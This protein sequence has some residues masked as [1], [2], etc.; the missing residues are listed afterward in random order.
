MQA[1]SGLDHVRPYQILE[2]LQHSQ[3]V[4]NVD[5]GI[6]TRKRIRADM[7]RIAQVTLHVIK[8]VVE[9]SPDGECLSN[10]I[11]TDLTVTCTKTLAREETANP[12]ESHQVF[13]PHCCKVLDNL[14]QVDVGRG[15]QRSWTCWQT[16]WSLESWQQDGWD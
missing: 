15:M 12:E 16:I 10:K 13:N 2:N 5:V 4:W 6:A 14:P 11:I 8:P 3:P 1:H 9:Q 7:C